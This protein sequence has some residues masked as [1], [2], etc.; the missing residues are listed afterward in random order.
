MVSMCRKLVSKRFGCY[1]KIFVFSMMRK[2]KTFSS[3]TKSD[4]SIQC[5]QLIIFDVFQKLRSQVRMKSEKAQT[6]FSVEK[7]KIYCHLTKISWKHFRCCN[8]DFTKFLQRK[9]VRWNLLK[10]FLA[11]ISWKHRFYLLMKLLYGY[12][13]FDEIFFLIA[14]IHFFEKIVCLTIFFFSLSRFSTLAGYE[15]S[16]LLVFSI[17]SKWY[18]LLVFSILLIFF[19]D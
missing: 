19:S 1:C 4:S 18:W 11:K 16:I 10:H 13:W 6:K 15:Y 12:G 7:R 5:C 9:M 2:R 8:V 3:S 14:E 17:L